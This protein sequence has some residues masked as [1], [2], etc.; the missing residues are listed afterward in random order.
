MTLDDR[1]A[2]AYREH[3]F[4]ESPDFV[5]ALRRLVASPDFHRAAGLP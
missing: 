2:E 4:H 3:P 5:Q 1:C